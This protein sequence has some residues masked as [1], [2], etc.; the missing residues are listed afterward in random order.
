LIHNTR[1]AAEKAG[2]KIAVPGNFDFDKTSRVPLH[3]PGW[4]L[5]EY[6]LIITCARGRRPERV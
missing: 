6:K 5:R 1:I 3:H 4:F 2:Q